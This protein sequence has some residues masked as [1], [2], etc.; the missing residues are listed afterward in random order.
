MTDENT[1]DENIQEDQPVQIDEETAQEVNE[2][3]QAYIG[4]LKETEPEHMVNMA[5]LNIQF[6]NLRRTMASSGAPE[7]LLSE[8]LKVMQTTLDMVGHLIDIDDIGV[9]RFVSVRNDIITQGDEIT[10]AVLATK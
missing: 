7:P 5:I 1:Q 2:Q 8:Y 10:K 4:K 6:E 3:L 9:E